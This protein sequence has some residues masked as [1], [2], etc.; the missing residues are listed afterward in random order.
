V[1]LVEVG[2]AA[3]VAEET[4]PWAEMTKAKRSKLTVPVLCEFLEERG[5][6]TMNDDTGKRFLKKDL[7]AK[8]E[9]LIL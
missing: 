8:V 2:E 4:H 3:P 9:N 6:T 5:I 1:K 7:L